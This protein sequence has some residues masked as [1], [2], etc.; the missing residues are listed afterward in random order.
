MITKRHV[1][2]YKAG[3]TICLFSYCCNVCFR[4][5]ISH[6]LF[7]LSLLFEFYHSIFLF[8]W[9]DFLTLLV[10]LFIKK[11]KNFN[12]RPILTTICG[13]FNGSEFWF[14]NNNSD[15]LIISMQS[16]SL[17]VVVVVALPSS[18]NQIL[19]SIQQIILMAV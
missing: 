10:A 18:W 17:K 11:R 5:I 2:A 16:I 8:F 14:L 3:D 9:L 19:E 15:K 4:A 1:K 6:C 13:Y 7:C 12:S